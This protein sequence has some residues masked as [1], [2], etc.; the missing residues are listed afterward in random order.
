[1]LVVA[2]VLSRPEPPPKEREA[3]FYVSKSWCRTALR[4]LEVQQEE[5]REKPAA[6]AAF[7]T[8][9]KTTGTANM[10][11]QQRQC[12]LVPGVF[13]ALPRSW[14]HRWR[15]FLKTGEGERPFAPDATALLCDAHRLPLVPP[16]LE[17]YLYGDTPALLVGSGNHNAPYFADDA[18]A[19][20]T[21]PSTPATMSAMAA[22]SPISATPV[23][24]NPV[25]SSNEEDD[26]ADTTFATS[27]AAA[28]SSAE[29]EEE[30][31]EEAIIAALRAAGLSEAELNAQRLAMQNHERQSHMAAATA[32]ASSSSML[33]SPSGSFRRQSSAS[34]I[35][36][37]ITPGN[38]P[39]GAGGDGA[40]RESINEQL[41]RENYRVVEI[42]TDEEFT[43]LEKWWPDISVNYALRFAV[44]EDGTGRR[45]IIWSTPPCRECDASGKNCQTFAGMRMQRARR[46]RRDG[47]V[48]NG[49]GR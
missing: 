15:K 33:H 42:L 46:I 25:H 27:A 14:C 45:N 26:N 48:P 16:H 40:T 18:D 37:P 41:D 34:T 30:E 4:W 44:A 8:P 23:G 3:G 49:K 24:Y 7:S 28:P 36:T 35:N 29:E 17:A 38:V 19:P 43:A 47:H 2:R 31:G 1:M 20:L 22:S 39:N 13:N 5:Q 32:S 9:G 11:S 10:Q 6:A 12:P 21:S